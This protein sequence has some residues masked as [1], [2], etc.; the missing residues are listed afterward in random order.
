M[1]IYILKYEKNKHSIPYKRILDIGRKDARKTNKNLQ[2]TNR[3]AT[4]VPETEPIEAFFVIF[5]S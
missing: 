3:I 4:N 5:Y 1:S 2:R